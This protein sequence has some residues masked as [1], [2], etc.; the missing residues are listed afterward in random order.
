MENEIFRINPEEVDWVATKHNIR[1][2]KMSLLSKEFGEN[3]GTMSRIL[4]GDYPIRGEVLDRVINK[5]Q[6]HGH[7]VMK[8]PFYIRPRWAA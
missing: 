7:L 5:L 1:L 8:K 6:Q 2:F 4:R 3:A